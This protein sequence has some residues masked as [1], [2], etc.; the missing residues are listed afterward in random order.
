MTNPT[1]LFH[2]VESL[3]E[4]VNAPQAI[5]PRFGRI[6]PPSTVEALGQERPEVGHEVLLFAFDVFWIQRVARFHQT[7]DRPLKSRFGST[8]H[9][10]H[11]E[12]PRPRTLGRLS[13]TLR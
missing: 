3:A 7:Q 4:F 10:G 2:A 12:R 8:I 11:R 6:S 13:R 1:T 9:D 5:C